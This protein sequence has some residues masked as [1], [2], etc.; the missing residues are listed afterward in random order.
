MRKRLNGA[1]LFGFFLENF[2]VLPLAIA[3]RLQGLH[4]LG[5]LFRDSLHVLFVHLQLVNFL[6]TYDRDESV[7][8]ACFIARLR[9]IVFYLFVG[10]PSLPPAAWSDASPALVLRIPEAGRNEVPF[11]AV[12]FRHLVLEVN[13]RP[14]CN[15]I[16]V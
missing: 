2:R 12:L 10:G 16:V 3:L 11:G 5:H 1:H 8:S 7:D 4:L 14:G 13:S 15:S 6:L 9:D